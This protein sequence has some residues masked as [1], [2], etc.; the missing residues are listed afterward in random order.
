MKETPVVPVSR[1]FF[2]LNIS[3]F[4]GALNDNV[5]KVLAILFMIHLHGAASAATISA[6]AAVVFIIPFLIFSAAAGVLASRIHA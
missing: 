5:F 6:V 1:S 4:C 3:Q 2:F